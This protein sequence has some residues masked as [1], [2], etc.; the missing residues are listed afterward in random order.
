MYK[1]CFF[2]PESHLEL[3]KQAL[4]AVGC[5]RMGNYEHCCWQTQGMGQ[6]RPVAGSHPYLGQLGELEQVAEWKVEMVV[7]AALVEPALQALHRAHPYETPAFD[8]W[9]L[10]TS[11]LDGPP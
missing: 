3:V 4:F 6:F 5:G 11:P 9:P 1:L 2:V 7:E 8:L 10:M